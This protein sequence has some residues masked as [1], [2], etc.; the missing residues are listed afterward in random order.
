MAWFEWQFM[1]HGNFCFEQLWLPAGGL[2]SVCSTLFFIIYSFVCMHVHVLYCGSIVWSFFHDRHL[3]FLQ[4]PS[5]D[6]GF[7][8]C[9]LI[10]DE[11]Q[12][13]RNNSEWIIQ[14][15]L[16]RAHTVIENLAVL[17][18]CSCVH[19]NL[20]KI[21]SQLLTHTKIIFTSLALLPPLAFCAHRMWETRIWQVVP[22]WDFA[23]R[24]PFFGVIMQSRRSPTGISSY[25][26]A[27]A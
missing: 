2:F 4:L 24:F 25:Y 9:T 6:C 22:R 8:V 7:Q 17:C 27:A 21:G 15:Q 11:R 1:K 13:E 12:K 26:A 5:D 20:K 16:S 18:Q 10:L 23:Q 3:G 14:Q 19:Y